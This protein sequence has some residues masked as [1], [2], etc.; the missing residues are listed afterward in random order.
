VAEKPSV[1]ERFATWAK[2][3]SVVVATCIAIYAALAGNQAK[4]DVDS[5]WVA[6]KEKVDNQSKVINKQ[7]DTI[8]KLTRRM[9]FFQAHQAG[10]SAGKLYEQNK[11]LQKELE[12][13]RKK[14]RQSGAKAV[15]FTEP[16]KPASARPQPPPSPKSTFQQIQPLPHKPRQ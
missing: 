7:S 4:N 9:I 16:K 13:L 2:G 8:E 6:L 12:D 14:R 5:T 15:K 1:A 10:M 3:L 11:R